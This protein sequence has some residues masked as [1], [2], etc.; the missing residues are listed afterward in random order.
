MWRCKRNCSF[1]ALGLRP[2]DIVCLTDKQ[3]T[4]EGIY[5]AF[6]SHLQGQ[7]TVNDVVVFHFSG[8]GSRVQV[9]D[10]SGQTTTLRSLVPYDGRLPTDS[11]PALNDILEIELKALLKQLKTKNVTSVIDAGFV[12]IPLPLSGGLRS[13]T[14]PQPITGQLPAPFDLLSDQKPGTESDAFP[15]IL[16]RGADAST[17][18]YSNDSGM[19]LAR[20]PLPMY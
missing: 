19:I 1:I 14:R 10:L 16:L 7:A 6:V 11:R 13:R 3:A 15:G 2:A 4:R 18:W 5:E 9:P 17:T 12:D 8:Y 20:G